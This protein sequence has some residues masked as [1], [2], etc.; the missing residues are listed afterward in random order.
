MSLG[1][2]LNS[3]PR[4]RCVLEVT[5]RD[6]VCKNNRQFWNKWSNNISTT[7]QIHPRAE[8]PDPHGCCMK[9]AT[10]IEHHTAV[11]SLSSLPPL[12]YWNCNF[13]SFPSLQGSTGFSKAGLSCLC[14][15]MRLQCLGKS[16]RRVAGT[17][18]W[19]RPGQPIP[20]FG[21]GSGKV[22]GSRVLIKCRCQGNGKRRQLGMV[23]AEGG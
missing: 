17:G 13:S 8:N 22:L 7:F 23:R 18:M 9:H 19:E 4:V 3:E 5:E 20:V 12:S 2:L 10:S 15:D 14:S 16:R 6:A 11:S 21:T 1:T